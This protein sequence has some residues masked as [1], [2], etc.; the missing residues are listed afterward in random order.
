VWTLRYGWLSE[1]D[2]HRAEVLPSTIEEK[3]FH[4][5]ESAL[6]RWPMF[7]W[8]EVTGPDG[9]VVISSRFR[10]DL[11]A[12]PDPSL[13]AKQILNKRFC[14]L[15][16]ES[17]REQQELDLESRDFG[18]TWKP[19][20]LRIKSAAKP[21]AY[22]PARPATIRSLSLAVDLSDVS[23]IHVRHESGRMTILRNALE[24]RQT[25][26]RRYHLHVKGSGVYAANI[27]ARM[28]EEC[29]QLSITVLTHD[30]KSSD[31]LPKA[32]KPGLF[33]IALKNESTTTT[34]KGFVR[35]SLAIDRR[36]I[37]TKGYNDY[38]YE[39]LLWVLT[40]APTGLLI[41]AWKHRNAAEEFA[42]E[43]RKIVPEFTDGEREIDDDVKE[44]VKAALDEFEKR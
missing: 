7:R 44:K 25:A 39:R 13:C 30:K 19:V 10:L 43:L 3:R 4:S 6:H 15:F 5:L 8:W 33:S 37:E 9:R 20:L 14:D 18:R 35:G 27:D 11:E 12:C 31:R 29:R 36:A 32:W 34:I 38:T 42:D 17:R 24:V 23:L 1:R 2:L 40:H 22:K 41:A 16:P 26:D 21:P 28:V